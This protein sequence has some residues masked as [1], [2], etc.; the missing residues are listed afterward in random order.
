M[1]YASSFQKL[2]SSVRGQV[3][4]YLT[5]VV[6]LPTII[7]NIRVVEQRQATDE[8]NAFSNAVQPMQWSSQISW[9]LSSTEPAF[10]H[11]HS[12]EAAVCTG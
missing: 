2:G 4:F 12:A 6:F 9:L 8:M 11:G 10:K 5:C 7:H 3:T 1:T